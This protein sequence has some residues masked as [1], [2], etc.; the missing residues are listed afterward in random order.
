MKPNPDDK[1]PLRS[2]N[3]QKRDM[4]IQVRVS[5]SEYSKIKATYGRFAAA[6]ARLFLCGYPTPKQFVLGNPEKLEITHAFHTLFVA[7]EQAIKLAKQQNNSSLVALLETVKN[8]FT[9]LLRV[10]FSNFLR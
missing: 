4:V 7:L 6:V 3:G 1:P 10:C 8:A 9:H 2:E 5:R